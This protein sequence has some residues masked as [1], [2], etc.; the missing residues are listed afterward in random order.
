MAGKHGRLFHPMG[1]GESEG[2][3]M[4]KTRLGVIFGSRSGEYEISLMSGAAVIAAAEETGNFE[5]VPIGITRRGEWKRVHGPL[6]TIPEDRWEE[7]AIDLNPGSLK[8]WVDFVFPVLHGPFGEDGTIQGMLE[9]MDIPYAGCGVLASSLAMDKGVAKEIFR[10]QDLPQ[11][12]YRLVTEESF[13]QNK[14]KILKELGSQLV[15][16]YFVKPANMGSS[17]GI[18]KVKEFD[19]LEEALLEAF[20]FD[21][22]VLVEEGV[23]CREVEISVMGASPEELLLSSIGEILPAEEFYDYRAKYQAEGASKLVIPA[24]LTS[25]QVKEIEEIARKAFNAID[26][27]GFARI[28]FF[29]QREMG[30]IYIN[31]IN[32]IP[33]FTKYSMM[34]LLWGDKGVTFPELIQRI[35]GYGY[36]RYYAKNRRQTNLC[37]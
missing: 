1:E 22:R 4:N 11:T 19:K 32:T 29:I 28:D 36:E 33:G 34:P 3:S 18:S 26:G 30:N 7:Q 21:R 5:V 27:S 35:V 8:E 20:R 17:V 6:S 14:D 16:P 15:L 12:E 23:N 24:D 31:E 2:I 9:M 37:R 25:N 10:V 13:Q